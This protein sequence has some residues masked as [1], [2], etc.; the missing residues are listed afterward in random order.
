MVEEKIGKQ[1]QY[2]L[3]TDE[4]MCGTCQKKIRIGHPYAVKRIIKV[5][6]GEI[7]LVNSVECLVMCSQ[8]TGESEKKVPSYYAKCWQELPRYATETE[9][10]GLRIVTRRAGN[11]VAAGYTRIVELHSIKNSRTLL[12]LECSASQVKRKMFALAP[13]G[14]DIYGAYETWT[15]PCGMRVREYK[16]NN[17]EMRAEFWYMPVELLDVEKISQAA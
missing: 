12:F 4:L 1:L 2:G 15:T 17:G 14:G 6:D 8:M 3:A 5:I 9:Q 10:V 11:C 13:D 7:V 16:Q